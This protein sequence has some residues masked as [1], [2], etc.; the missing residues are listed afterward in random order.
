MVQLLSMDLPLLLDVAGLGHREAGVCEGRS[1]MH[2]KDAGLTQLGLG[3]GEPY[4]LF[5]PVVAYADHDAVACG[6]P[7]FPAHH[8]DRVG[9]R[10]RPPS[11]SPTQ[12]AARRS[13]RARACR[14][15]PGRCPWLRS[16][17]PRPDRR[18]R[19]RYR[20]APWGWS[21]PSRA[22]ASSSTLAAALG[23]L[24][25]QPYSRLPVCGIRTTADGMDDSRPAAAY[26]RFGGR[27]VRRE[28]RVRR[29]V[30]TDEHRATAAAGH[31]ASRTA[32]TDLRARC[33]ASSRPACLR[34]RSCMGLRSLLVQGAAPPCVTHPDRPWHPVRE[35]ALNVSGLER[36][37]ERVSPTHL[38]RAAGPT[39]VEPWCLLPLAR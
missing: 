37:P 10:G 15:P 11:G 30:D 33:T 21:A 24:R 26:G 29:V 6:P 18:A 7:R 9:R 32:R 3:Q 5:V 17:E 20:S 23:D 8:H 1:G 19:G 12:A 39:P 13:R 22:R 14:R 38:R 34:T 27:P 36:V 31:R 2:Q 25:G 35:G 28:P 16:G 4:G